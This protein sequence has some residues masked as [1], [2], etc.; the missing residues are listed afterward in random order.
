MFS[1]IIFCGLFASI[2]CVSFGCLIAPTSISIKTSAGWRKNV[3]VYLSK[4]ATSHQPT[5]NILMFYGSPSMQPEIE[6]VGFF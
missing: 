6:L 2:Q 3:F 1:T 4:E 5:Y